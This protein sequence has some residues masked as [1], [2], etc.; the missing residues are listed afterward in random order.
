[1][2]IQHVHSL[3]PLLF[4]S[5]KK[6]KHLHTSLVLLLLLCSP[7]PSAGTTFLT[8]LGTLCIEAC[9]PDGG[10]FKC[11]TID[12]DGKCQT[13]YCSPQENIDYWGR[14]CSTD[15]MCG[16]H[17]TDYYW[18]KTGYLSWGY[19]GQVME[20]KNHY[21]SKTGALCYDRCD[22]INGVYH[23]NTAEGWDYCSPSENVD[24][25]NKNCNENNPCGKQGKDYYWCWLKEGSWGYCGLVEPKMLLHRSKYHYVCTDNCQYYESG[26]YY[27]CHTAQSWG[28]CSPDVNVTYKDKPCRSDHHCGLHGSGYNWCWT[29]ESEYDYC[30]PIESAECTYVTSHHRNRRAPEDRILICIRE[31][32]DKKIKTTFTAE[33][34]TNSIT[35]N[36]SWRN[37][38]SN[39]ISRWN[40]GYLVDQARS[41]LI[42]SENLR[43]DMQ[44]LI[45][46]NNQRYYN[47]QIQV[48]MNRRPGQSTTVSQIIIPSGVP[49][50]YIRRAF[51]ESFRRR[52]RVFVDVSMQNHC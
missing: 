10:E 15:S 14:E 7:W 16:K 32:K 30:G 36:H 13:M 4:T 29:S 28:Y 37:E 52:A 27:W 41:N 3:L 45:N 35:E 46:R 20:D 23:C 40:N 47:L 44:G 12:K 33:P 43:I 22:Q 5:Q 42:T 19:C 26:D 1:M 24:Y 18:C 17:G 39:L 50:R 25:W 38:A 6:M 48:N 51:W 31:N 49:D 34:A 8:H 2:L 11:K 21:G 9:Q